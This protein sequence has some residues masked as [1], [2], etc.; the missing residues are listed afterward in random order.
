MEKFCI[1]CGERPRDKNKEHVLPLWLIALTGDPK[2]I[3]N[4]GI[5]LENRR[6]RQFAFDKLTFPACS[7]CN[8]NFAI[9]EAG[10]ERI[11]RRLLDHQ[12]VDTYDVMLLL[13]WLDKVRVGLWLGFFY[14]HK[15]L[16]G[17]E[18]RFHITHRLGAFDRMVGII[19]LEET[20]RGLRFVGPVSLFFQLSPTCFAL[21]INDLYFLNVSGVSLCSQRLGFPYQRPLNIRKDH[22]MEVSLHP[23][24]ERIMYPVERGS[25]LP[26]MVSIYQPVF[27]QFLASNNGQEYLTGGWVKKYT[28]DHERG[29]GKLFLQRDGSVQPFGDNPSM[30]WF[31]AKI[32]KPWQVVGRLWAYVFGRLRQDFEK[33]IGLYES[34]DDRRH[35]RMNAS[36]ARRMDNAALK[37]N[38]QTAEEL[39]NAD[40]ESTA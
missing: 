10:A 12:A 23:G 34:A 8:S 39:K 11:V 40:F 6:V 33:A 22:Q 9:L 4:F 31:P 35:Q 19:R 5:D 29:L 13:D 17:I 20:L 3:V 14:L 7:Q 1:F 15:N 21:G 32:W 38:A 18:P 2:R 37:Q 16:A 36:M 25:S 30:E 24:S 28:A 26:N 27:K